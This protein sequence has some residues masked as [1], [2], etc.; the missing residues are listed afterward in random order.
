MKYE[1]VKLDGRHAHV[2]DYEFSIEFSKLISVGTGVLDF[3]RSRRWFNDQFGWSQDVEQQDQMR[4][5]K[6]RYGIEYEVSD[7]N[8][9]WAYSAKYK[10]YRI[11]VATDKEMSWYILCHPKL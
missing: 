1:V 11:Y 8:N 6:R 7:I 2:S 10:N 3:D 9:V 5:N 4:H